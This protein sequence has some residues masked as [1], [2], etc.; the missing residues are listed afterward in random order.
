MPILNFSGSHFEL[1]WGES[2]STHKAVNT[3][4]SLFFDPN[5]FS[6]LKITF[7]Q[8]GGHFEFFPVAILNFFCI[9]IYS[10]GCGNKVVFVFLYNIFFPLKLNYK[11]SRGHF[12]FLWWI[13]WF[14]FEDS[15]STHKGNRVVFV[16]WSDPWKYSKSL[17][18]VGGLWVVENTNN[19]Y[20][21]SLNWVVVE[22]FRSP[23]EFC[24]FPIAE[25]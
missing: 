25:W 9:F 24:L 21:S 18:W 8:F 11:H 7:K 6:P 12:E 5:H 22:G 1:F 13:F 23:P 4:W 16:F 15:L 14:C 20:H 10:Q 19:H 3:K 2:L 17:W